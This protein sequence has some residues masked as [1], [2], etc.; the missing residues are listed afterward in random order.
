MNKI[1]TAAF[2]LF[3][4]LS[5][6]SIIPII[7][8][9]IKKKKKK[10]FFIFTGICVLL[11]CVFAIGAYTTRNPEQIIADQQRI[12]EKKEKAAQKEEAK[13]QAAADAKAQK[14]QAAADAEL[15]KKY[16]DQ[17]DYEAWMNQKAQ[18]EKDKSDAELQKKYDDQADYEAWMAQLDQQK[19]E[20]EA[21]KAADDTE[22]KENKS[23]TTTM[24]ILVTREYHD[25][26]VVQR[27]A[28]NNDNDALV[29]LTYQGRTFPIDAGTNVTVLQVG[30]GYA[31][32]YIES[33][34][35]IDRTGYIPL[36]ALQ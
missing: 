25:I 9:F 34:T 11:F 19:K 26:A 33:G 30:H 13:K 16:D 20:E 23:Y 17:A 28:K 10:P 14:E 2:V 36:G 21:K 32:I 5:V 8:S 22:I 15:Q 24:D 35:Y 4:F 7:Y 18:Q 31:A 3:F 27:A 1:F 12:T 6:L 29:S